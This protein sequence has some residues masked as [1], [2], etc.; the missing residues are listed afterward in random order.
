MQVKWKWCGR[1]NRDNLKHK[2]YT[3]RNL[4]KEAPLS[5]PIIYFV[6]FC[7][8]YIQMSLFLGTFIVPKFWMLISLSNQAYFESERIIYY[9]P[10]KYLSN[11][12]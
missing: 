4:W 1:F 5:S 3:A 11:G 10:R 8:D 9:N 6:P 12:L 2:L 7:E